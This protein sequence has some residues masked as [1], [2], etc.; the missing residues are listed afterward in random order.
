MSNVK[1]SPLMKAGENAFWEEFD[2]DREEERYII[3]GSK[4]QT[5]IATN[6]RLT[7]TKK[8]IKV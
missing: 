7:K 1:Q 5:V 8:K 6:A 2:R 4:T 3:I